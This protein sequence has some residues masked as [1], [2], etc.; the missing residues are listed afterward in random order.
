MLKTKQMLRILSIFL[1]AIGM[2][3]GMIACQKK[4]AYPESHFYQTWQ[5][6]KYDGE[7]EVFRDETVDLPLIRGGRTQYTFEKNGAF[8][9][10]ET[11]RND[12][13]LFREGTWEYQKEDSVVTLSFKDGTEESFEIEEMEADRMVIKP[14]MR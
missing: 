8:M 9:K 6:E 13:Y 14:L 12:A 11:G 1:I 10:K 3:S 2:C 7:L 5:Y 4:N